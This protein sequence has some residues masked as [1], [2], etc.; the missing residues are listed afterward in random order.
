VR[1]EEPGHPLL[2]AWNGARGFK[3]QDELYELGPPYARA[4]RRVL[5]SVDLSDAATAAV[6]PLHRADRDFAVAW[7]KRF[8]AGRVFYGMFGHR[9]EPFRDPA[10][11]RFY[12]DGIQYALGDLDADANATPRAAAITPAATPSS[13]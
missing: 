5:I 10:V 4:D 11:L 8:G 1:L 2:R 12:L 7:I 6:S 9:A 3:L 13:D